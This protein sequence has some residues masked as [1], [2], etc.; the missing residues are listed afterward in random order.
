MGEIH[1]LVIFAAGIL[2]G[3][4][5]TLL[6]VVWMLGEMARRLDDARIVALV[7]A[8]AG[9]SEGGRPR[10]RSGGADRA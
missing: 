5:L 2:L 4:A 6:A 8:R 9:R 3:A 1:F 7:R 10:R